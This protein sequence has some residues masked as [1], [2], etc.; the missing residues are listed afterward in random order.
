MDAHPWVS[1]Q[2]SRALNLIKREGRSEIHSLTYV[3]G[4]A[5]NIARI[6]KF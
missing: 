6:K 4:Y 1:E 2:G 5:R 3:N